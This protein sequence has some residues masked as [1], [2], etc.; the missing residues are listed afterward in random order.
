MTFC[1]V[2]VFEGF[3]RMSIF[4]PF[5]AISN[6]VAKSQLQFSPYF[7]YVGL[8]VSHPEFAYYML[9]CV[10]Q[11]L[12]D[13]RDFSSFWIDSRF[14]EFWRWACWFPAL[15]FSTSVEVRLGIVGP[16]VGWL[17]HLLFFR[18][19]A[20]RI[21]PIFCMN[22]PYYKGKKRTRRFSREK[23]GSFKNSRC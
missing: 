11:V 3:K 1:F 19:T 13:W 14:F 15:Q 7:L 18:K 8:W 10:G 23:S 22:V 17:V 4:Y 16:S 5:L 21:F 2:T 12:N 9:D 6:H 20:H